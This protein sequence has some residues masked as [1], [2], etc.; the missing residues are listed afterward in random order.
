MGYRCAWPNCENIYGADAHHIRP[1]GKGGIDKFWNIICLCSK[2]HK[3]RRLH[4]EYK[5]VMVELYTYKCMAEI[6]RL[7]FVIDEQEP[8]FAENFKK[9]V[10][11]SEMDTD[12]Q[13]IALKIGGSVAIR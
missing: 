5:D 1:L 11:Q 8:S 9:A 2:C 7:G 12:E 6:E 10:L 3:K 4:S 13:A